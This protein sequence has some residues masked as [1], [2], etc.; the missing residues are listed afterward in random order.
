MF[1]NLPPDPQILYNK[2]IIGLKWI[3][4]YLQQKGHDAYIDSEIER[5]KR[6]VSYPL[7]DACAKMSDFERE[8]FTR[9]IP[10]RKKPEP[11]KVL[12]GGLRV[13]TW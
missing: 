11:H 4:K 10:S 1:E 5:F 6:E 7:D 9:K 12:N 3:N 13:V 2:L 8:A